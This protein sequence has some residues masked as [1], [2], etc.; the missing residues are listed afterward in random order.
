L[1]TAFNRLAKEKF[2]KTETTLTCPKCGEQQKAMMPTDTCRHFYKC[3][4]CGEML[5]PKEGDCCVF[6]SYADSKCPSKQ[7][8]Q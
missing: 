4:K 1:E 7:L 2:L 6:C 8:E 5:K 3:Q